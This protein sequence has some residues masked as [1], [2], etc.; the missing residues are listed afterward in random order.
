MCLIF[1]ILNIKTD[2]QMLRDQA[3][4]LSSLMRH[5]GP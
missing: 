4:K 3:L 5:R 2:P 1:G